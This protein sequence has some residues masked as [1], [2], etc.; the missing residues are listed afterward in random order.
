MKPS[1]WFV[2]ATAVAGGA[3]ACGLY[4]M[5]Q[6]APPE[7]AGGSAVSS[8]PASAHRT[9]L[10][11]PDRVTGIAAQR[12][13]AAK[14]RTGESAAAARAAEPRRIFGSPPQ[15]DQA[16]VSEAQWLAHAAKVAQEA[17]HEL[18]RLATLLDLNDTQQDQ[19]FGVLARRSSFWIPGMQT[20]RDALVDGA[21]T[22]G[23]A[24]LSEA[25]EVMAYLNLDQQQTIIEEEMDRQAWWEEVLPQLLPPDFQVTT[26]SGGST[27]TTPAA[28]EPAPDTKAFDG[29]DVLLEE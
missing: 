17:N 4:V 11:A 26:D 5:R 21:K 12:K 19:V 2:L 8:G 9:S 28:S 14:R 15:G 10:A 7:V 1:H 6:Q 13:Q 24:G 23:A 22:A 27:A 18:S 20:S 29:A 25:D 16:V 3:V